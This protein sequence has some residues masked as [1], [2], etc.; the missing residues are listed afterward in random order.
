MVQAKWFGTAQ[1]LLFFI[2][3]LS[4]VWSN[5]YY[6]WL[7]VLYN[8]RPSRSPITSAVHPSLEIPLILSYPE[9]SFSRIYMYMDIHR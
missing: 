2:E 3:E 8:Y 5:I 7:L 1:L 4:T 9:A 6:R